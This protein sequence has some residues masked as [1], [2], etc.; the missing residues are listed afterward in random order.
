MPT[1]QR[2]AIGVDAAAGGNNIVGLRR[3]QAAERHVVDMILV[4]HDDC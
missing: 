1:G 2:G 3:R 4:E